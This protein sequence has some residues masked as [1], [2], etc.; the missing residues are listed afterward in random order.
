VSLLHWEDFAPGQTATCGPRLVT[1]EEI[2]SF[3][4]QYDAQ[5]IHLDEATANA[6][7]LGGLA[8]SGFHGCCILMRMIT[9][10]FL[11]DTTFMGAPGVE[12]VKWLAPLRPGEQLTARSTVLEVRASRSRPEMGFVR[13]MFELVGAA[14]TP[15]LQLTVNAMFKR[16]EPGA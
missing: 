6:S 2:L 8:A 1:R 10:G 12:E 15:L 5:A 14:G 7:M 13:T 11:R 16:R 4:R 3:A 9:D